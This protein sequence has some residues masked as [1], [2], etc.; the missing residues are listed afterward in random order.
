VRPGQS[1]VAL[2]GASSSTTSAASFYLVLVVGAVVAASGLVLVRLFG[3][4]LL[5]T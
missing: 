3:V 2:A 5:W 1:A 4:K